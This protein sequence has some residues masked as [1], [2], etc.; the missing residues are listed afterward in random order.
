MFDPNAPRVF[1]IAPGCDFPKSVVMGLQSR[2]SGQGPLAMA[3]VTLYVNTARMRRRITEIFTAG[4]ASFLPKIR[5]ITE[6]DQDPTVDLP[7]PTPPLRRKLEMA[8]LISALLDAQP[9]LA[10][11]SAIFDLANSLANLMDEMEGEGVLPDRLAG[12]DVSNHSEHW[13]RAQTFLKIIA[14][15]YADGLGSQAR[16]RSAALQIAQLWA[17]H[18][19]KDPIIIA[20]STGSRGTTA[21]FMQAVAKLP[22]GALILPGFD[23]DQPDHVWSQMDDAMT[24]EDHPQFRFRRLMDGLNIGPNDIQDWAAS[25]PP[26]PDRNKLISLSLRPAPITHQWLQEGP[27][28]PDLPSATKDITLIEA[29][30]PRAEALAIALVLRQA[31]QDGVRAALIS[32][33]RNLT[34]QVTAALDRW[35]ILP[36]DSAGRPLGLTAPGRFLRQVAELFVEPVT[37]DRLLALLK[38]PLTQSGSGRGPH[39]MLTRAL[40]LKLRRYGPAFPTADDI[41]EWAK[42]QKEAD[43]W[44]AAISGIFG[45][46]QDHQNQP[47]IDHVHR[48]RLLAEKL[49]H[50]ADGT[51]ELWLR[52]AGIAALDLMTDLAAQAPYGNA[53]SAAEYRQLFNVLIHQ[54]DVREPVLAHPNIMIWGTIEARV[55]GADLVILGGLNDLVWPRL[56][57]PDPWLN[58]KM[59]KDASLLLPERQIGLSA[60]DYQQ[61]MG[62]P[63]VVMTR[64]LR[65]AEAET[66]P[67]RWLNRLTNLMKGLPANDGPLAL[68]QM[69]ARGGDWVRMAATLDAPPP[70]MLADPRWVP[71]TRPAPQPPTA[72]R[73]KSLSL[74]AIE[75]LIRDPFEIYARHIL[76]LYPLDPLRPTANPRDRG[77]VVH[78]IL[79]KFV[80]DRPLT[81]TR[82][83]ARRR[84]MD[85]ARHLLAQEIP[86]PAMRTLWLAKLD[87]AADHFLA[88]DERHSGVTL[89][90]ESKGRQS[91]GDLAFELYGT[92]DRIDR[93]TDGRLHLI[94]YK[95]GQ[96]PTLAQQKSFAKQLLLAAAMAERGGFAALGPSE[97]AL[98]TYIGLGAGDKVV[99]KSVTCDELNQEWAKL[100]TLIGRYMQRET[101]YAARRALFESRIEGRYDHLAR[102]GE[103]QMT[104][105]A[106]P[107]MVGKDTP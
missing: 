61:A 21:L 3:A 74:T 54:G 48:H 83:A 19:P 99:E 56:P 8:K 46:L 63:R 107:C 57:D 77:I 60:H 75:R 106:V 79:Q 33:D 28:L 14:P 6:I 93:L 62:A 103:W 58:R 70:A 87:R 4:G 49:A 104:D 27:S 11:R 16:L 29:P 76:R 84:L 30:T 32:P 13:E 97:V 71:A 36:D 66:V 37:P 105:R 98:I 52:A 47:L 82:Q 68:E 65:N 20:G 38:H 80:D 43:V 69:L 72:L 5:L 59:R 91:L 40:E 45:A 86:F 90:V 53:I 1:G 96:T 23:F 35:A 94:D 12:L 22:Q 92:P 10:P 64:A 9:Q 41:F 7:A 102:F 2:I 18:P 31:A 24:A 15:L 34:R 67:S 73:P 85:I 78:M 42:T 101:G 89:A 55:Q 51:G 81:E 88:E 44:V 100:I 17:V 25:A 26:A 39:Q 50:S 95:T